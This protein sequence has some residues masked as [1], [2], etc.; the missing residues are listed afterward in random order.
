M[1]HNFFNLSQKK[2]RIMKFILSFGVCKSRERRRNAMLYCLCVVLLVSIC[3][4]NATIS[5]DPPSSHT[6]GHLFQFSER[7]DDRDPGK[8]WYGICRRRETDSSRL[9][10][11]AGG[12]TS[13]LPRKFQAERALAWAV[14]S[15]LTSS[16][17]P[18]DSPVRRFFSC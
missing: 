10:G 8:D 15:S 1:K 16:C 4:S 12:S 13:Q 7:A 17:C 9:R 11:A 18:R 5:L 2:I 6:P 14:A 3:S